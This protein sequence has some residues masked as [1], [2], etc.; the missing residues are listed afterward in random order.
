MKRFLLVLVTVFTLQTYAQ[1]WKQIEF[2]MLYGIGIKD[3][4]TLWAWGD[5]EYGKLGDGT[6]VDKTSPIQVGAATNWKTISAGGSTSLG[7]KTDGTLWAWGEN[8]MGQIPGTSNSSQ[9]TPKK[10]GTA[11]DWKKISSGGSHMLAIKEN[12]TLWAWGYNDSGALGLGNTQ[13]VGSPQQVGTATDWVAISAAGYGTSFAI[14]SDGTLW[15]WGNNEYGQLGN[16][17]MNGNN[18]GGPNVLVPTQVG[19]DSDWK[20]IDAGSLHVVAQK[21]DNTLWSWGDNSFGCLGNGTTIDSSVPM[22]IGTDT[23]TSFSVGDSAGNGTKIDGKLYKWGF[24]DLTA[25]STPIVVN[26]NTEWGKTIASGGGNNCAVKLNGE[27]YMSGVNTF[28]QLGLGDTTNHTIPVFFGTMC[29]EATAGLNDNT[30]SQ[31]TL[32]PNPTS[33]TLTIAN[34]EMLNIENLSVTDMTGKLVLSQKGNN[35]EINVEVLPAGIYFLNVSTQEG[36]QHLK[37]VKE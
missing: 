25:V 26:Q 32:Y 10:I 8:L 13:Q 36:V 16:G 7:L 33:S 34:A 5:N 3:N 20:A 2:G 35:P 1:C 12:G 21:N 24:Q 31:I 29:E 18:V 28:G 15:S 23:W 9:T 30:L 37:F 19:T 14:K 11:T 22:Q 6:I 17:A 4:G 27:L